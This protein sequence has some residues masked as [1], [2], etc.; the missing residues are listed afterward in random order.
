MVTVPLT[1]VSVPATR[2]MRI[3]GLS[4]V[5]LVPPLRTYVGP[6]KLQHE[7][8]QWALRVAGIKPT[9]AVGE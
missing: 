2:R 6:A 7:V 3:L 5:E 1:A 8:V 4:N 9:A